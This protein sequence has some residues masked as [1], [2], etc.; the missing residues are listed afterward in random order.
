MLAN[1]LQ[2]ATSR[3]RWGSPGIALM[4]ASIVVFGVALTPSARAQ[5]FTDLYNFTGSPD[6]T[7]PTTGPVRDAAGNLFGTT[8]GGGASGDGTVYK[9]DAAGKE[10]VLYNFCSQKGCA[11]GSVPLAG[12]LLTAKGVLY[13]TTAGG[14]AYGYGTVF[15]LTPDTNGSWTEA[16]LHSFNKVKT[17]GYAPQSI[18]LLDAKGN[19]YGTTYAGGAFIHTANCKSLFQTTGCGIA[20]ELTP[21]KNSKWT[22]KVLYNFAGG[23]KDG[24]FPVEGVAIDAKGNLYGL[25]GLGGGYYSNGTVYQLKPGKNGK[26]KET[27]LYR[28]ASH[29]N[30]GYDP[31]GIPVLDAQGNLYGATSLG[32]TD[33]LGT[34][35]KLRPGKSGHWTEAVLYNF[36]QGGPSDAADPYAGV[37][38]DAKGN[39]YG[40]T[41]EG[42]GG[43][44]GFG[45]G[46]VFELSK[47]GKLKLLFSFVNT[48]LLGPEGSVIRDAKGN[49][50]GTA[51]F[52]GAVGNQ[53]CQGTLPGC[54]GV[55]KLTP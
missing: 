4:L 28:F 30:D 8:Y 26:W 11:D 16:V 54:G 48:V 36:G 44:Q 47:T 24:A 13:G 7:A 40:S 39:L 52:G 18:P 34:V 23:P 10:T 17:D 32:G 2:Q 41:V 55:F 31:V 25:T 37:I 42:G 6:G 3:I 9:V 29:N 14:G 46:T 15:Q 21:G 5:T 33:G 53:N 22:E 43:C 27:L 45:C 20:F 19:L 50:Y 51:A 12:L 49:I 1:P 38:L 35:W